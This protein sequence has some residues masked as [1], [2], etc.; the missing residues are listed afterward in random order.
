M[1]ES[2][3]ATHRH[4]AVARGSDHHDRFAVGAAE[5]RRGEA[6][7]FPKS[8]VPV[9]TAFLPSGRAFE[10]KYLDLEAGGQEFPVEVGRDA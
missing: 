6:V 7:D 9:T 1:A 3:A 10:R 5:G 4:A 8:T 2:F